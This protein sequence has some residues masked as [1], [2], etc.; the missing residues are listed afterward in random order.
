MRPSGLSSSGSR[1]PRLEQQSRFA[2]DGL[3]KHARAS[4][5]GSEHEP[6]VGQPSGPELE[7]G[8]E[9][10]RRGL[11]ATSQIEQ[12][13]VRVHSALRR[14]RRDER[15]LAVGR[16]RET[17]RIVPGVSTAPSSLPWRSNQMSRESGSGGSIDERL[18]RDREEGAVQIRADS[19]GEAHRIADH[20]DPL[21][22]ETLREER[23][24]A[25]EDDQTGPSH[26]GHEGGAEAGGD[27]TISEL[28]R[29]APSSPR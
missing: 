3:L 8:P 27:Q 18:R 25:S 1:V 4:S 10:D 22:V 11:A 15:A 2:S 14:V 24:V 29:V 20:L 19:I 5:A 9:R 6:I 17:R 13:E 21:L 12:P 7:R 28:R 26:R 23:P 16:K